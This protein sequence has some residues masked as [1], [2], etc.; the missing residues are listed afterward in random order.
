MKF[1]AGSL[2]F[3]GDAKADDLLNNNFLALFIGML[4]DQQFPI[5]RA[6]LGPHR[7]AQRLGFDLVPSALAE[8]PMEDLIQI[9]SE[10]PALHR[11][12][13]AMAT[14]THALC[15]HLV[16]HYN[17]NPS[18]VW[19]NLSHAAELRQRLL[20]IPGFGENKTQ[21][22]V[23]LLA[24]RFRVTPH[25]WEEIAGHYAEAGFHSVADLDSPEALSQLRQQRKEARKAK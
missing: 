17:D 13:K 7:L 12:P 22:F 2:R 18:S 15:E 1:M 23:A 4:L 10:K 21:I 20:S 3:T 5:E 25:G 11:F 19:A 24:K 8:L 14:R 6:F 9:F 16:K